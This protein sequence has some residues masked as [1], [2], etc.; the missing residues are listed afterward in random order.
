MPASVAQARDQMCQLLKDAVAASV[1]SSVQIIWDDKKDTPP[2]PNDTT[3]AI[4]A[5][6]LRMTIKHSTGGQ[7]SLSGAQATK[8]WTRTGYIAV[9]IFTP[10][11]DGMSRADD[12]ISIVLGAFEGKTTSGGVWFREFH[13]Q[14]VG[15]SGPWQQTNVIGQFTFDEIK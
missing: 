15:T 10:A 1:Y 12:I 2:D 9:Q 5:T 4:A 14:E 8:R 7:S 3:N 11:G 6:W 13:P